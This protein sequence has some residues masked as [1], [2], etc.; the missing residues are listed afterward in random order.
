MKLIVG[1]DVY[2]LPAL[3]ITILVTAPDAIVA[4][5]TA[6]VPPPPVITTVGAV[7]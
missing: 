2:P 6:P 1:A 7:L 5:A 4:V 3:V